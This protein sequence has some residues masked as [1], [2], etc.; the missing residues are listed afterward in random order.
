[1]SHKP[2][3]A[4]IF[5]FWSIFVCIWCLVN[6]PSC[7]AAS[8][9]SAEEC[10][11]R[12]PLSE[13]NP[14][15]FV[16]STGSAVF[17]KMQ[18]NSKSMFF[19]GAKHKPS[20]PMW[21]YGED[22]W[23][24]AHNR[25]PIDQTKLQFPACVLDVFE[26][27]PWLHNISTAGGALDQFYQFAGRMEPCDQPLKIKSGKLLVRKL[28]AI[29]HTLQSVPFGT[30]VIWLDTDVVFRTPQD[31]LFFYF[32]TQNYISK[33]KTTPNLLGAYNQNADSDKLDSPY[34]RIE[35]GIVV[36]TNDKK[37][38]H[39][40]EKAT[41]MYRGRL[42]KVSQDCLRDPLT[43][44]NLCNEIWFQRN[45]YLDDIFAFSLVLHETKSHLKHGWLHLSKESGYEFAHLRQAQTPYT[46]PFDVCDYL[47]HN[48]G[49]GAYSSGFR[50]SKVMPDE[51]L[52]FSKE[53]SF[54]NTVEFRFKGAT[55]EK[56]HDNLWIGTVLTNLQRSN[57]ILPLDGKA[58][59]MGPVP[60]DW[61]LSKHIH[62]Y[63]LPS[64]PTL[65]PERLRSQQSKQNKR[66]GG[67]LRS[68]S[69]FFSEWL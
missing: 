23:D 47:F 48:I 26:A 6:V 9:A 36:I 33:I 54:N 5:R 24:I 13:K 65:P 69:K 16:T 31:K 63:T 62:S 66:K 21:I 10:L 49:N 7:L 1:M 4:R 3:P 60:Q 42:L 18:T 64:D 56:L 2:L 59:Q 12:F 57:G 20:A 8:P 55:P 41:D 52:L 43:H 14:T 32:P 11:R 30:T 27:V 29:Y 25:G 50:F 17:E 35:S 22:S 40:F 53:E 28:A 45:L 67:A 68:V 61:P 39:L 19:T 51:E 46:T 37:S 38:I 15:V 34:W 44:P 58:R